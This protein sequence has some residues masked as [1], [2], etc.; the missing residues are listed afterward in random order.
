MGFSE[1]CLASL[2]WN[3]S[4]HKGSDFHCVV[5]IGQWMS[6]TFLVSDVFEHGYAMLCQLVTESAAATCIR[7]DL[8][9]IMC[10]GKRR[11][12]FIS[13]SL[14]LLASICLLFASDLFV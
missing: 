5:N 13:D 11:L 10:T 4:A 3:H 2:G 8:P 1:R 14:I 9:G 6:I 7:A 12:D